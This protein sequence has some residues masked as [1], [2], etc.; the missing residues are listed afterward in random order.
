MQ[1]RGR[2]ND[3]IVAT[4]VLGAFAVYSAHGVVAVADDEEEGGWDAGTE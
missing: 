4:A 2:T 3:D 1:A